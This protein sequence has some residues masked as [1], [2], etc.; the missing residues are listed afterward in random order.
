MFTM[1]KNIKGIPK[2]MGMG[3]GGRGQV[4]KHPRAFLDY[5]TVWVGV[6]IKLMQYQVKR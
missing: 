3:E 1:G 6:D 5:V 2:K 4:E